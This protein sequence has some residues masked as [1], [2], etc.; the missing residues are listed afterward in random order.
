MPTNDKAEGLSDSGARSRSDSVRSLPNDKGDRAPRSEEAKAARRKEEKARKKI[1][2]AEEL[3]AKRRLVET[4]RPGGSS[5]GDPNHS[6]KCTEE[7]KVRKAKLLRH[8]KKVK[9]TKYPKQVG[10]PITKA[11][12][13]QNPKPKLRHPDEVFPT[14]KNPKIE[15]TVTKEGAGTT[16]RSHLT[17]LLML[18]PVDYLVGEIRRIDD[19]VVMEFEDEAS[20]G[21][22]RD[23]VEADGWVTQRSAIWNRYTFI[24]PDDLIRYPLEDIVRGLLTRN[25]RGVRGT[26]GIPDGSIR[27]V[28]TAVVGAANGSQRTRAFIDI[29]PEGKEYL[30]VNDMLLKTV[31]AAIRV[32]PATH[33]RPNSGG[34]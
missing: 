28:S 24:I 2:R 13:K 17:M 29:S 12:P 27:A 9:G 22:V 10:A 25:G 11:I 26:E 4:S 15:L 23:A 1:R 30:R 18:L 6:P 3:D 5:D 31:N 16:A 19:G 33:R 34:S 7:V 21:V 8:P 14:V 20:L 32:K